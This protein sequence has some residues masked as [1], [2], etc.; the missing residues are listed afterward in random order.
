MRLIS[1]VGGGGQ[2]C[3]TQSQALASISAFR[4]IGTPVGGECLGPVFYPL[5]GRGLVRR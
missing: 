2:N 1:P 5:R 3:W 4:A